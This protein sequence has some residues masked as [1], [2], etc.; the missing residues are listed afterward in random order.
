MKLVLWIGALIIAPFVIAKVDLWRRR[1][2][3]DAWG[4]WETENMPHELR[5]ATLFLSEQ[6]I[7]TSLPVQ[8]HGRVDQVYKTK[9]GVLI[10]LDTKSRPMTRVY[11]S[12]IIQISVYRIILLHQY[13]VPVANY[14]YV[15]TVT[16]TSTGERV[17]YIKT[18]LLSERQVVKLW[19]R[20]QS[21][22]S[23]LVTPSCTCGGDFHST[24]H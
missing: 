6:D 17:R 16:E 13:N 19:R 4:W 22:R 14:G 7:A 3:G 10:P 20:Y 24:S 1:G 15:R 11:E 18:K 12:D 9:R 23:G 5:T 2:I 21:I 8:M